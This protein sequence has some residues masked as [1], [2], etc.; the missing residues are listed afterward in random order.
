MPQDPFLKPDPKPVAATQKT[1]VI[2]IGAG[3]AGLAAASQLQ[4]AG[5]SVVVLEAR[6]RIGG[7]A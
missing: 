4:Q 3:L 5:L 6:E 2:V 1:D 7:R